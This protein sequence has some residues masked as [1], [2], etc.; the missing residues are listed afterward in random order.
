MLLLL[1]C[2]ELLHFGSGSF[3]IHSVDVRPIFSHQPI[4]F[5]QIECSTFRKHGGA[6]RIH[7]CER[8]TR[9]AAHHSFGHQPTAY[10]SKPTINFEPMTGLSDSHLMWMHDANQTDISNLFSIDICV[11]S[12]HPRTNAHMQKDVLPLDPSR[13]AHFIGTRFERR[14]VR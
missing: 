9:S 6:C 7:V 3:F 4:D 1:R 13:K 2:F 8:W 5:G 14:A 12:A 11:V 10:V